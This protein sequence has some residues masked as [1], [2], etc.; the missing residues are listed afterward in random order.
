MDNRQLHIISFDVPLPSNYG[1]VI[2][3]FN[4]IRHLH[5]QGIQITLHCF[6]YG[7]EESKLLESYCKRVYYYRRST[8]KKK[9]FNHDPFIVITRKH[10]QLLKRLQEDQSPILFEGLH[11]TQL[12]AIAALQ[13]RKK[14]VRTH[15]IEHEYYQY[16][17]QSEKNIFRKMY[18]LSESLKLKSYEKILNHAQL[19]GAISKNDEN[20]FQKKYGNTF[21][22]PPFHQFDQLISQTGKGKYCLY[23]GNLKV[24]ENEKAALWLVDQIAPKLN[25]PLVIAGSKCGKL[26]RSKISLSNNI[27]LVEN[28]NEEEMGKLISEAHVHLLPSFQ[29]S[30][31]KLKLIH[32]LFSGRFILANDA[33]IHGTMLDKACQTANGKEEF[34][35]KANSLFEE[36]FSEEHR[37]YRKT[38]L[39][40]QYDNATNAKLFVAQLFSKKLS[41][42]T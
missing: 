36:E 31:I 24:A 7:R 10:P 25:H 21:L 9:L 20:Y 23:H 11:T 42:R 5:L 12:L 14:I 22:L 17:S 1:G 34:A 13:N 32:A 26:L 4:K 41:M 37:E 15:N 18:L 27:S 19:I 16:L 28:P 29:E 35:Q 8:S 40:L 3:V 30:G 39:A 6:T 2:D 38:V 33:M